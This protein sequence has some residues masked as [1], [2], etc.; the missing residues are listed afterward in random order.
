MLLYFLL[1]F[2]ISW[3]FWIPAALNGLDVSVFPNN[4]FLI[5]GGL[6]PFVC[7]ILLT[8]LDKDKNFKKLFLKR[9]TGLKAIGEKWAAVILFTFPLINLLAVSLALLQ[10]G[11]STAIF[12]FKSILSQPLSFI[13]FLI[14]TLFF[15]PVPEEIG[16]RGYALPKLQEKF[17]A[18]GASA[19]LGGLWAVWHLPLFFIQG[20]YQQEIGFGSSDFWIFLLLFLPETILITWVFNNTRQSTL[21]AILF[22]FMINL[23]GEITHINGTARLYQF[24]LL[25]LLT[26]V[27][28]L[29]FGEKTLTDKPD[30]NRLFRQPKE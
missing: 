4:L 7:G 14:S 9:L 17:N 21:A 20:T 23:S 27:I 16:W 19:I 25:F 12:D 2:F 24:N 6:G 1:T 5:L 26:A 3:I 13:F 11:E 18:L 10:S 29:L 15:G 30:L 22:H 28:V 8:I